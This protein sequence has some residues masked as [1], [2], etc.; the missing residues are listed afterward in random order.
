VEIVFPKGTLAV[1]GCD[2][3]PGEIHGEG[4]QSFLL[5]DRE[6]LPREDAAARIAQVG[7][8]FAD[9]E[10][11]RDGTMLIAASGTEATID[12]T[13]L[14]SRR[15]RAMSGSSAGRRKTLPGISTSASAR[16]MPLA[17]R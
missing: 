1:L 15:P 14:M 16:V 5:R 6:E 17:R 8:T 13:F 10:S 11:V 3:A 7:E 12:V 4:H 2:I 9:V